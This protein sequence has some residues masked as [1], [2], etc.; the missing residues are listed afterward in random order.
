MNL[1]PAQPSSISPQNTHQTYL[2]SPITI[3]E[4]LQALKKCTSRNYGSFLWTTA[5]KS[6]TKKIDTIHNAGLRMSI[7]AYRSSP[8]PSIYN[9]A[10]TPPLEIRRLKITL[11]H[12]LKL[13]STLPS[14][15]FNP[16]FKTLSILLQENNLVISNLL[17]ISPP[18]APQWT[19]PNVTNTELSILR[20][21]DTSSS[22]YKQE[23][24][25]LI[26]NI[27]CE[28]IYT[29]ASKNQIG[30]GAAVVWNNTEFMY[31][32]PDSCSVFTAES[33]AIIKTL[34]LITVHQIQD[35]I[36][37]TDSLSAINNT[38]NTNNPSDIGLYI[39][40]KIYTLKKNNN[41]KIKLFWIPGH[42]NI[43]ENERA[44]L[45]AKTAISSS[46]SSPTYIISYRDI[47][48]LITNKCHL[49]WH[50]KWLSLST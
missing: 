31:K 7:G 8:V 44:D 15:D 2:N 4:I 10:C 38:K 22:I 26:Q 9:L 47:Q 6:N 11:N 42:S 43:I 5:N 34:E 1:P 20:K 25:H 40:N 41:F 45:A 19:D 35:T 17:T 16:K 46:L 21:K 32:L 37:F 14:L 36:I 23:Y 12:E 33:I 28:K 3:D 48:A 13:A 24:F 29:D 39:Q 30:V 18:L 50:Q 27:K 49:R